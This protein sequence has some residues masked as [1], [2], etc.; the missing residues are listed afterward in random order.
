MAR[1]KTD[2]LA[3][4]PEALARKKAR[5][6]SR[7][8]A[9]WR[10]N[11]PLFI[12]F[13]IPFFYFLIFCYGPMGG[14]VMAFEQYRPRNGLFGSEWVGLMN[15]K[16]IFG[17]RSMVNI[18]LN[19]VRLGL[20]TVLVSFP[21]PIML[22][23]LLNEVGNAKFKKTTQTILYLP[24]FFSWVIM[25]GIVITL[26]SFRG[27]VNTVID[28][29]GGTKYGFMTSKTSWVVIYLF[30]GVWKEMG[31]DAIVYLA[32][33]TNIDPTYYE[34]AQL[35]GASRWQQVTRITVPML[36]PTI[37]LMFI[38]ATGRV[39][40]VGFDRIYVLKNDAV[41]SVSNVVSIYSY[42]QGIRQGQFSMATAM[43]L[44]DS[45]VSLMLVLF[46]NW[47][48]KRSDNALF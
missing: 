31:Y 19:T 13:S 20:L 48:A 5:D 10:R 22:A 8:K 3:I 1:T 43:G 18:I 37:I 21:F 46:T 40:S 44:F 11:I 6:K 2:S 25:G 23:I 32:A 24:H 39:M 14:L 42:E 17:T 26:F 47:L 34:A 27:P 35:D 4:S 7:K 41:A 12:M 30:A 38:L 33:L 29:L 45:L 16:I 36:M 9:L 28:A 15:F